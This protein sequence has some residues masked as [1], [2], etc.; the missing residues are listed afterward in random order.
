[1]TQI[2]IVFG[3]LTFLA[4]VIIV[5]N[6]EVI[7]GYLR[8]NL[9]KI[10]LH[11]LAVVVRLLLGALLI[12]QSDVSRFPLVIEVIGWLSIAAALLLAIMGR[13]NFNRL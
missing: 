4:G 5:I 9:D 1:M 7:F 12:F 6:P 11:V 13:R 2:I 8:D 3:A 10:E